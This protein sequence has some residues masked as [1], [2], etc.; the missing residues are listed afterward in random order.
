MVERLRTGR[1]YGGMHCGCPHSLNHER[2]VLLFFGSMELMLLGGIDSGVV[3]VHI[4]NAGLFGWNIR[5]R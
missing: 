3:D 5:Q 2:I 1:V 4:V